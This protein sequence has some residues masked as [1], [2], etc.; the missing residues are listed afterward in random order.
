MKQWCL[1]FALAIGI[2]CI[3]SHASQALVLHRQASVTI[4]AAGSSQSLSSTSS[5][6]SLSPSQQMAI[7]GGYVVTGAE[8]DNIQVAVNQSPSTTQIG[9]SY[10]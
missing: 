2:L 10:E 8:Q 6:Q 9:I 7:Q 1:R 4:T 5:S 3:T